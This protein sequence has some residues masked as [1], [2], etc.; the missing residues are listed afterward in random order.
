MIIC[1]NKTTENSMKRRWLLAGLAVALLSGCTIDP[2]T[3]ERR[4]SNLGKG[5]GIGAAVGAGAGTLF[6]GNDAAN[7]GW[8]AL[9]GG[10]VGAAVGAYM[11]HQER[12]MRQSLQGTGIDVQR[13]GQNTLNLTMPSSITFAFD[14]ATLTPQAQGA[15]DSV[16][17][18]LNQYPD[19]TINVTGHTDD[20]GTDSYNQGLSERRASSV[21]G[22]LISHGVNAAR[23]REQGMGERQPK[24]PN[25]DETNRSQ[26]RRVEVAILANPNAGA[27]APAGGRPPQGQPQP[28]SYPPPPPSYPPSGTYPPPASTYP[29]PSTSPPAGGGYGYPR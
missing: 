13:T 10:A 22:Y 5:A 27:S 16:A 21:G 4:I 3:G 26:N 12:A 23:I 6:G 8:G 2:V 18:V 14:S 11:D 24:L 20:L 19:T 17:R 7:A 28:G 15:L 29:N 9:A 25:T 1:L